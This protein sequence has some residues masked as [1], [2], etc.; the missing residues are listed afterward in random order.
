MAY[1]K[2]Y[3]VDFNP[4]GSTVKVGIQY[5]DDNI[6]QLFSDLNT[7]EALTTSA[8][9]LTSGE[10][11]IVGTASVDTLTNKTIQAPTLTGTVTCSGATLTGG[12]AVNMTLTTPSITGG[13]VNN[14]TITGA[15]VLNG[16]ISG[17]AVGTGAGN[18]VQLDG[19]AKLPAVDGSLLTNVAGGPVVNLK[20]VVNIEPNK[21]DIFA[22]SSG[23]APD[24]SN[25]IGIAIPDGAGVTVRTRS[26]PYLN[27][28][29]QIVME[30]GVNYWS[31]GSVAG[32][33]KTAWLYAIWDGTGIVWALSGYSGFNTVP[34]T[35]TPTDDDFFLLEAGSTYVRNAAHYCVAVAKI[36]YEY[37]IADSPDHTIQAS[38]ENAPQVIWNPK[39]DY[40][41]QKNLATTITQ[42]SDIPMA[43]I[44]SV[45]VKQSGKYDIN[46]E[47][48]G[49]GETDFSRVYA[50]LK[51]GSAVFADAI[52]G[53]YADGTAWA[54]T[55][56]KVVTGKEIYLN[57]GDTIHL[58]AAVV[59]GGNTRT[60]LG[61]SSGGVYVNA[62]HLRFRRID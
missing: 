26:G 44:V 61:D 28:T 18:L 54:N 38:G 25:P 21:L 49:Q 47:C 19:S 34:T 60:I 31:K 37:D 46:I 50:Y 62:T 12:T 6:D 59:A 27:G 56:V 51:T 30:D 8:H 35:T 45:V 42:E 55:I 40:G 24:A 36:R 52:Y 48:T 15:I 4:S 58:G 53:G 20:P 22:K 1:V 23:A 16:T 2:P 11:T 17:S 5:C 32:E 10:G 9:G 39:S 41:Y 7:H 29:S 13:T 3:T 43:S 14:P 57:T 33:I